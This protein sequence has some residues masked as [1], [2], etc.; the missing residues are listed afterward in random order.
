MPKTLD[1]VAFSLTV[2][3][4]AKNTLDLTYAQAVLAYSKAGSLQTGTG[5]NQA[6]RI[7]SDQR[8]I[9]PSANDDL[10]LAGTTLQDNLGENLALARIKVI[11]VSAAAANA[12]VLV[13]GGAAA[14]AIT[15][16]LG[17]T[18]PTLN[19]RPG[20]LFLLTAPDATGFAITAT[21][22]DILRFTNG[23]AGTSVTYD[24]V[25]I[26]SSA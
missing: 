12:N 25:I 7:F 24:V 6:D 17:G 21:T 8:T 5:A 10:D 11:A 19:I 4:T 18:S 9:A 3:G 13:M 1:N 22:A 15:T 23:G 2:N 26:G 14:A 20:G 16:I